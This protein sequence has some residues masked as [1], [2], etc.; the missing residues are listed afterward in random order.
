MTDVDTIPPLVRNADEAER[1]WFYGGGLHEWKV[2]SAD[3]AGTFLLFEDTMD[4][5]KRTPLHTHPVDETMY[6]LDGQLTVHVAGVDHTVS[7]GGVVIAP[8]GVPHA[9]LV[10]SPTARVLW[11]HTPGTCEGF[12]RAASEP[13]D[14]ATQRTVDFERVRSAAQA[15]GGIDIIGPPPFDD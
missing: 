15:A 12:Y 2:T 5:G 8:R 6:V 14:A 4:H 9:F 10:T 3:S 13:L 7:R 1:R 11:L